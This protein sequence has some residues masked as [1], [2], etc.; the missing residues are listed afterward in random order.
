MVTRYEI[1]E[2]K[3][4]WERDQQR[5]VLLREQQFW[6]WYLLVA[7]IFSCGLGFMLDRYVFCQCKSEIKKK[8]NQKLQ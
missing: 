6:R 5:V 2:M 3:Q 7:M 1:R 4:F 8:L